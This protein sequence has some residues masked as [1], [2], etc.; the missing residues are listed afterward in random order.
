M[1][2]APKQWTH[3][4]SNIDDAYADFEEF[5]PVHELWNSRRVSG[6]LPA[7]SEFSMEDFQPWLGYVAVDSVTYDP[8]DC[9]TRLWGTGLVDIYKFEATGTS[10]L[11]TREMRGLTDGD[12]EFLRRVAMDPCYAVAEG[13]IDWQDREHMRVR[14]IFFPFAEDRTRTDT[15][16]AVAKVAGS[17]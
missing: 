5:A 6:K 10:A 4:F 3:R 15:I 8:F 16:V 11:E 9:R 2:Y 17:K 12:F 7:W 1:S 13:D 14:R